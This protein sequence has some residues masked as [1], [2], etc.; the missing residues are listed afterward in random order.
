V[1]IDLRGA[2]ERLQAFAAARHLTIAANVRRAI[3]SML[4]GDGAADT[5]TRAAAVE[6]LNE[7]IAALN[8][9]DRDVA[10]T[11]SARSPRSCASFFLRLAVEAT[12]ATKTEHKA[13]LLRMSPSAQRSYAQAIAL[14]HGL[15]LQKKGRA[16]VILPANDYEL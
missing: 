3:D 13:A 15:R 12:A 10:L 5:Y 16:T 8:D 2:E 4:T 14:L 7:R 1:T 11:S 9:S 6:A